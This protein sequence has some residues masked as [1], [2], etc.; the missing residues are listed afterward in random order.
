MPGL[1]VAAPEGTYLA[2]VDATGT[3]VAAPAGHL[4]DHGVLVTD[5]AGFG[6]AYSGWFRRNFATP[7][8]VLDE[9]LRRVAASFAS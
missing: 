4:A 6:S 9:V 2:W 5:G 7:A 8:P 3:G 1:R